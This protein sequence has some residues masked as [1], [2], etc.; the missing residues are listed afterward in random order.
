MT[1]CLVECAFMTNIDEANLLKQEDFRQECADEITE[2]I[3]EYF[4]INQRRKKLIIEKTE[5]KNTATE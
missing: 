4:G 2:G 5:F 1:S 3:L